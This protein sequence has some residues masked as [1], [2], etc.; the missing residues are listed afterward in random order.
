MEFEWS[1]HVGVGSLKVLQL[2]A[3]SIDMQLVGVG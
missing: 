1:L 3:L 2:S